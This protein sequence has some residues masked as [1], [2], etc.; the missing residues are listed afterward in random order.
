MINF[1]F[2]ARDDTSTNPTT[3]TTTISEPQ[4]RVQSINRQH[5]NET[6]ERLAKPKS[7]PINQSVRSGATTPTSGIALS[8][9]SHQLR[10]STAP[11]NSNNH[12]TPSSTPT[13][14]RRVCSKLQNLEKRK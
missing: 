7:I 10:L 13:K 1:P 3:T 5:L 11:V 4:R 12:L 2:L 6:I 8:Q 9:S 14:S